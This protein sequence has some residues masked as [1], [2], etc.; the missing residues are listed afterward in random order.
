MAIS[1]RA[2]LSCALSILLLLDGLAPSRSSATQSTARTAEVSAT[3]G[4]RV[5]RDG[6][7][8]VAAAIGALHIARPLPMR[9]ASFV[10]GPEMP[11]RPIDPVRFFGRRAHHPYSLTNGIE[12]SRPHSLPQRTSVIS[13]ESPAFRNSSSLDRNHRRT[14]SGTTTPPCKPVGTVT[15]GAS[16][17]TGFNHWW[18]FEEGDLPGLGRYFANTNAAGNVVVSVDDDVA[19]PHKG[20]ELDFRR[21]YNTLSQHDYFSSDN[22]QI[23]N[24]GA[25]WTNTFD[26]HVAP[27][28]GSNGV[29]GLTVYDVDGARYDYLPDPNNQQGVYP[30]NY[31]PPPG[32]FANLALV[33]ASAIQWTKPSGT[34]YMFYSDNTKTEPGG[35]RGRVYAI[36]GRNSNANLTFSY[37]FDNNKPQDGCGLSSIEVFEDGSSTA[38]LTLSFANFPI[39]INGTQVEE[40]LLSALKLIFTRF[41]GRVV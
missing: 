37:A 23:S 14:S 9:P 12:P 6:F 27:N 5:S 13:R 36:Y 21:T 38:A 8:S 29:T 22:S 10:A 2:F 1:H 26:A 31:L 30:Q 17:I 15:Y 16:P 34:V 7:P 41:D 35:L 18:A 20:V 32:Q 4:Q 3:F 11:R 28:T 24:Y 25:G 19:V 40:R 39:T 33:S